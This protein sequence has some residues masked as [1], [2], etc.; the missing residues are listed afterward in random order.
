MA[1]AASIMI[2]ILADTDKALATVTGLKGDINTALGGSLT[3]AT[4]GA[5]RFTSALDRAPPAGMALA[6]VGAGIVG[7]FGAAISEAATFEQSISAI[8]AVAGATEEQMAAISETA[9]RIGA[10][11]AF[12]AQEAAAGME[13]LIKG[14]LSV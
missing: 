5:E 12:S 14:G 4:S 3:D 11:T 10:D 9:L 1:D 2:S 6:G 8:G 13:E 7:A